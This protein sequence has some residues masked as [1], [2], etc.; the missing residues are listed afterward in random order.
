MTIK[1]LWYIF[2]FLT[3]VLVLISSPNVGNISNSGSQNGLFNVR[4]NQSSLQK[5]IIF[6]ILMFLTLSILLLVK[7]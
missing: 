2:S 3:L 7:L 4:S 5:S 1:F 6:T